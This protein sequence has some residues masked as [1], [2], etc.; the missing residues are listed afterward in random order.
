[1]LYVWRNN[2]SIKGRKIDYLISNLDAM[3]GIHALY[4]NRRLIYA[5]KTHS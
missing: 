1:M 4:Y 3:G 2:M 5:G